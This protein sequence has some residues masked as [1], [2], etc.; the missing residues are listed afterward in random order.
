VTRPRPPLWFSVLLVAVVG[1]VSRPVHAQESAASA[2]AR[3]PLPPPPPPRQR[4]KAEP[5]APAPAAGPALEL[6]KPTGE[7]VHDGFY[8]RFSLGP[9]YGKT[10]VET[11]RV[12]QPDVRV[13]GVGMQATFWVGGTPKPGIVIGGV[14]GARAEKSDEG[15][16]G[17]G[18]AP[19]DA[20]VSR[21]GVFID[22]YPVPEEGFH[23]GGILSAGT[24]EV[25]SSASDEQPKTSYR[26]EGVGV[27]VFA[28]LDTWISDEWSFGALVELGGNVSRDESRIDGQDVLRQ[29]T[30]YFLSAQLG[31]VYH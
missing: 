19:V 9:H 16:V 4:E 15:S 13:K 1:G 28:G 24:S 22:A 27:S 6:Q 10:S 30:S 8:F 18:E 5:P 14:V 21:G 17:D 11:D 12:S 29:S 7:H 3:L 25:E 26:G 23:F 31:V 20:S 2:P